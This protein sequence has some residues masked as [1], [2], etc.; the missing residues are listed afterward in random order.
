[1]WKVFLK[2][3][4][5][6]S[7]PFL[8]FRK[9]IDSRE[10]N[11]YTDASGRIGMGGICNKFWMWKFWPQNFIRICNPSYMQ[12]WLVSL[13]GYICLQIRESQYFVTMKVSFTF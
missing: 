6:F 10:V 2:N 9:V 4:T 11:F 8:D 13:I 7:R 12:W 3:P 5:A 1:M